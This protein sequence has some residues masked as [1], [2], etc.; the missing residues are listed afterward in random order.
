MDYQKDGPG[1]LWRCY[2]DRIYHPRALRKNTF[3]EE[4]LHSVRRLTCPACYSVLGK[5]MIYRRI[6][7][8]KEERPA[9]SIIFDKGI[10]RVITNKRE[11]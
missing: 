8:K 11:K 1:K 5:P 7:P 4:T 6:R 9:F 3:T 2:L 10:A